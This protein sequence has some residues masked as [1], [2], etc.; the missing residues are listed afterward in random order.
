MRK[1]TR[2]LGFFALVVM[3]G[4]GVWRAYTYSPETRPYAPVV[5]GLMLITLLMAVS[6]LARGRR[7]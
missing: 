1:L 2:I 5:L 7:R 6:L 3:G 4:L